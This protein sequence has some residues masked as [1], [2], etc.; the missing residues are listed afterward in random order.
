MYKNI[1]EIILIALSRVHFKDDYKTELDSLKKQLVEVQ[2][3]QEKTNS[4]LNH[5]TMTMRALQDEKGTIEAKLS[6]KQ[7]AYQAQVSEKK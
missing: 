6:Q 7:A 4:K 3:H 1:I 5:C 2:D